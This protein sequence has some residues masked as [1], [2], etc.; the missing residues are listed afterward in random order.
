M[1]STNWHDN[2]LSLMDANTKTLV[3]EFRSGAAN[4]HVMAVP[5]IS[6]VW[7]VSHIGGIATAEIS[8]D[9][10]E[11][12]QDPN[13][14]L[15]RGAPG[16]HGLWF[17]DDGY[18]FLVAETFNNSAS[19]HEIDLGPVAAAATG[20]S[21]PLATG[22]KNGSGAG[23]CTRGFA[24]NAGTADV[25]IYSMTPT[26]GHE[27]LVRLTTWPDAPAAGVYKNAA[28]N[29][30]LRVTDSGKDMATPHP[31]LPAT[32]TIEQKRWAHLPIQTPISP[33]DATT[34]GRFIVTANK[35]S[36]NVVIT[37]LD[38]NGLPWGSFTVPAGL[39]AHGVTFGKK[40]QCDTGGYG[41]ICY[42]AYVTNTFED[43]VSVYDL[44][45]TQR[46]RLEV[47]LSQRAGVGRH[48]DPGMLFRVK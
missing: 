25:A 26:S 37:G 10:L 33:A 16:P 45:K 27:Q 39:G 38:A 7:F 2:R 31:L 19:M 32:E 40:S 41:A 46:C 13:I 44:E 8:A 18:H 14:D 28:D 24:A 42:Y 48:Y 23:G 34:H 17:C 4:A 43:Y 35:A 21:N 6:D 15:L 5:G 1:I 29:L 9:R 47:C 12:R 11:M 36:F 22:I 3:S 20:G 30:A